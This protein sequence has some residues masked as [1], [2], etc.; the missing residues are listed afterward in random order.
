MGTV[1]VTG[2]ITTTAGCRTQVTE[3]APIC[4]RPPLGWLQQPLW[5]RAREV[6]QSG[7]TVTATRWHFELQQPSANRPFWMGQRPAGGF[8]TPGVAS[9]ARRGGRGLEP[10]VPAPDIRPS[11]ATRSKP[12]H[13]LLG[14]FAR[15]G[16][17][18]SALA[19]PFGR[20]DPR[21][22]R[23]AVALASNFGQRQAAPAPWFRRRAPGSWSAG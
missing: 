6:A 11:R 7:P 19:R 22:G 12:G 4:L 5:R 9:C 23:F 13:E 2:A 3:T 18:T 8:L 14:I 21:L 15:A 1:L 20:G 17:G 10:W 16:R